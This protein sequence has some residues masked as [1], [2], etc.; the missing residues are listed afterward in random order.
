[1]LMCLFGATKLYP[2][3]KAF[4]VKHRTLHLEIDQTAAQ[5]RW[6][7]DAVLIEVRA[8]NDRIK[9]AFLGYITSTTR[10]LLY[11]V[12]SW[13]VLV[14]SLQV[15]FCVNLQQLLLSVGVVKVYYV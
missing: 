1:M 11:C 12:L 4:F 10:M 2:L 14:P 6:Q 15:S 7:S 5:Y 9:K 3:L 8:C 13:G